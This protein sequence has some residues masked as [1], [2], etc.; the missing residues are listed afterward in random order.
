M[1]LRLPDELWQE[2][3]KAR[4]DVPRETWVRDAVRQRVDRNR[5]PRAALR[6]LLRKEDSEPPVPMT[7]LVA[8]AER[9]PRPEPSS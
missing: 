3:E 9:G 2:V 5:D 7:H 6:R 4:R 8:G 1:T